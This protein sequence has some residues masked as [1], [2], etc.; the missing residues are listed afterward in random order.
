MHVQSSYP[1]TKLRTVESGLGALT[2]STIGIVS[3]TTPKSPAEAHRSVARDYFPE[4]MQVD[5]AVAI[6]RPNYFCL[7]KLTVGKN[8]R[9]VFLPVHEA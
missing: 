3:G 8:A 1:Y 4:S 7:V 6:V 2:T 9:A 5:L